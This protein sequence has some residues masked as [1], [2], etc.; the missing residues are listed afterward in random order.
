MNMDRNRQ[1]K[2]PV[3]CY[4]CNKEEHFARDC[5]FKWNVRALTFEEVKDLYEQMDT[6]WKDH[7][8]IAKKAKE[9]K[10]FP[11]A[12]QWKHLH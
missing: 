2:P 7:K 4:N 1:Q 8:E 11:D 6:A 10:D 5:R 3:K 12:T 9:T